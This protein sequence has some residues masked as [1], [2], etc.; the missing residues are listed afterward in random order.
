MRYLVGM[1]LAAV[2]CLLSFGGDRACGQGMA[3]R[4]GY[5][6]GQATST[7]YSPYLN[8]LRPGSLTGNYW[9]L[10]QPELQWRGAVQALDQ[11]TAAN[12]Q[13]I[14]GLQAQGA[15]VTGH[16]TRFLSTGGYFMSS[17]GRR[18]GR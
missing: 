7:P 14:S 9:G 2:G 1:T 16:A 5:G 12:G 3:P 10:V 8:L 15:P 6:L 17:G 13:A 4:P 11:Q 18:S